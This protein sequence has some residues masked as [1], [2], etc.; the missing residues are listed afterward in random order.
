MP[1]NFDN[2][3]EKWWILLRIIWPL[4]EHDEF[5]PMSNQVICDR[6]LPM[7]HHGKVNHGM[8]FSRTSIVLLCPVYVYRW[9]C[10]SLIID[11]L[12]VD[13]TLAITAYA[14]LFSSIKFL[15]IVIGSE[16]KRECLFE[17]D[18]VICL[19]Y[20]SQWIESIRVYMGRFF[21]SFCCVW[22]K[23]ILF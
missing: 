7:K 12:L 15:S 22:C 9:S 13:Y 14:C 23:V 19:G 3:E 6:W 8:T 17:L 16:F 5:F 1:T 2:E 18:F 20:A 21:W 4:F 10:L 11:F